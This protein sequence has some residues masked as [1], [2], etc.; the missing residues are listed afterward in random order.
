LRVPLTV[1]SD[2]EITMLASLIS[3]TPGTLSLDVAPDGHALF[4]HALIVHD[5]GASIRDS[6]ARHLE[7]PVQRAFFHPSQG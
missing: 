6:I 5:D 2:V 1:D 4:V 3:L 7:R